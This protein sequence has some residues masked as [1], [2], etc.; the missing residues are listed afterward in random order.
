MKPSEW[1]RE[2]LP[3]IP[4]ELLP[5]LPNKKQQ[6]VNT[7]GDI[8]RLWLKTK[9]NQGLRPSTIFMYGE[10]LKKFLIFAQNT[11]V[12]ASLVDRFFEHSKSKPHSEAVNVGLVVLKQALK[13]AYR[14]GYITKD[15]ADSVQSKRVP[16]R[17]R[18]ST[19]SHAQYVTLR[20]AAS[21]KIRTVLTIAYW[22]GLRSSDIAELKWNDIDFTNGFI[23]V[24]PSKTKETRLQ[25][26]IPMP[27]S[28]ELY[29]A[30]KDLKLSADGPCVFPYHNSP[31]FAGKMLVRHVCNLAK[32]CG[33]SGISL[34]SFRRTFISRAINNGIPTEVAMKMSGISSYETMRHYVVIKESVIAEAGM[35]I[36]EIMSEVNTGRL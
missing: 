13:W 17:R 1:P 26:T 30:L 34:H 16:T 14:N 29:Q 3:V 36:Q 23:R 24:R 21:P 15:I 27:P 12:T 33:L 31:W 5:E 11:Q 2:N 4:V 6:Q 7:F 9:S 28:G 8:A 20:D 35:K 32:K 22:T 25:A 18:T 10:H 19:V